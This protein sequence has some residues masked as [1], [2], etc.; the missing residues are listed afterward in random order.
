MNNILKATLTNNINACRRSTYR[1]ANM[2]V[3]ATIDGDI[4]FVAPNSYGGCVNPYGY[5]VGVM[6]GLSGDKNEQLIAQFS[7]S[8][9]V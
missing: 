4:T 7:K 8:F 5:G 6:L 3:F 9:K 1:A 2:A